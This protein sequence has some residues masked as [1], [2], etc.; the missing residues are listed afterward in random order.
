[1]D[2]RWVKIKPNWEKS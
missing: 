2:L 1:M